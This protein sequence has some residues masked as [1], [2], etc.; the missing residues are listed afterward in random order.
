[1]RK[2]FLADAYVNCWL[3]YYIATQWRKVCGD[4]PKDIMKYCL[5][6]RSSSYWKVKDTV[7][8]ELSYQATMLNNWRII[9]KMGFGLLTQKI[10]FA[11]TL[12]V[13]GTDI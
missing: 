10:I 9:I 6:G 3:Q 1:M 8:L 4:R 13:C 12:L 7:Y 11:N 2:N 5:C